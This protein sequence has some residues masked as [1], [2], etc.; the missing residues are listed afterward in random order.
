MRGDQLITVMPRAPN[1]SGVDIVIRSFAGRGLQRLGS[2]ARRCPPD[3][4]RRVRRQLSDLISRR[5]SG[6][7]VNAEG[8]SRR[9]AH[10]APHACAGVELLARQQRRAHRSAGRNG[11]AARRLV[12][13][14]SEPQQLAGSSAEAGRD[15]STAW[16]ST[17]IGQ[18]I[19]AAIERQ[20]LRMW[21]LTGPPDAEPMVLGRGARTTATTGAVF[22]PTGR[23]L[24]AEDL[25]GVTF[26]PATGRWPSVLRVAADQPRDVAFDPNGKWIAAASRRGGVEVWPSTVNGFPRRRLGLVADACRRRWPFRRTASSWRRVQGLEAC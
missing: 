18:W 16:P 22:E 11:G 1:G 13:P 12:G 10:R 17:R 21:D 23:W 26:W 8:R 15:G 3:P 4:D 6:V 2:S 5:P 7:R 20:G 19:V 14:S 25:N 24:A 9:R